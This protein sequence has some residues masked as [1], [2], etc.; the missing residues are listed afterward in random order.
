MQASPSPRRAGVSDGPSDPPTSSNLSS[1]L[2]PVSFSLLCVL[3]P[4]FP[5]L[6][7]HASSLQNGPAQEA[8][9]VG[10]EKALENAFFEK[11]IEEYEERKS[12]LLEGLDKLGLP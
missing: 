11:Q 12:V 8:T 7:A 4:P 10:L 1:P 9:A 5:P 3:P 2:T 6:L